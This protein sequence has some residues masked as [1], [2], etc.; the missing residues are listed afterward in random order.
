M[1]VIYIDE[2]PGRLIMINNFND[3]V[4][5]SHWQCLVQTYAS[6]SRLLEHRVHFWECFD[7]FTHR[8]CCFAI[9]VNAFS[10]LFVTRAT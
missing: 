1:S 7:G 4:W 10:V 2:R 6:S 8:Q 3:Y 9:S 5:L